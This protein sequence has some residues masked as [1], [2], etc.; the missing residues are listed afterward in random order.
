MS[1]S[2]IHIRP[3]IVSGLIWV[4]AVCKGYQQTTNE[5]PTSV[6]RVN[7]NI[8]NNNSR[9][10]RLRIFRISMK[11]LIQSHV[12]KTP[13]LKRHVRWHFQILH[14]F[15]KPNTAWYFVWI[16]CWQL[17]PHMKY[18]ALFLAKSRKIAETTRSAAVVIGAWRVKLVV[19]IGKSISENL[20]LIILIDKDLQEGKQSYWPYNRGFPNC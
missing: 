13:P 3:D 17:L 9:S 14:C 7:Y 12:Y 5:V 6:R 4:Q 15:K 2:L 1:N 18:Q 16:V 11:D 10:W 19:T 20:P 8:N